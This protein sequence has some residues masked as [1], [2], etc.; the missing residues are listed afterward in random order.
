MG[1]EKMV[2]KALSR[3]FKSIHEA[4]RGMRVLTDTMT[5]LPIEILTKKC[6]QREPSPSFA[7][8]VIEA[9]RH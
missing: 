7:S 8:D 6:A 9:L 5:V 4:I 1:R 3:L 2:S